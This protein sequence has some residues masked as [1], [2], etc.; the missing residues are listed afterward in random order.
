MDALTVRLIPE[1]ATRAARSPIKSHAH[2][3]K[4]FIFILV[5]VLI[6]VLPQPSLYPA[7]RSHLPLP[8]SF[9]LPS[10]SLVARCAA[11]LAQSHADCPSE[12]HVL[13]STS[14]GCKTGRIESQC[15]VST[16]DGQVLATYI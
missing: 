7:T 9:P 6:L 8:L 16:N 4:P 11:L 1:E 12:N 3:L 5:L 14:T 10:L 13:R 2:S 15:D